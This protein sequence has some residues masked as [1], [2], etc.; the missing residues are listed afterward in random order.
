MRF[1]Y[2]RPFLFRLS[3]PRVFNIKAIKFGVTEITLTDGRVIHA[4][5]KIKNIKQNAQNPND[6][7]F[8]YEVFAELTKPL[9]PLAPEHETVQ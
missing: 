2:M 7:D 3:R 9:P 8:D 6:I 5:L 4:T 1:G